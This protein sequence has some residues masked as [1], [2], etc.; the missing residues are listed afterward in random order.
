MTSAMVIGGVAV[1]ALVFMADGIFDVGQDPAIPDPMIQN[2]TA[3]MDQRLT[4]L[5]KSLHHEYVAPSA[6]P[7]EAAT[8]HDVQLLEKDVREA[9]EHTHNLQQQVETLSQKDRQDTG[10]SAIALGLTQLKMAYDNDLSLTPGIEALKKTVTNENLQKPL[11]E[12]SEITASGFPTKKAIYEELEQFRKAAQPA[13]LSPNATWQERA[14]NEF[15]KIVQIRP[16]NQVTQQSLITEIENALRTND[17]Q[18]ALTLVK[19]LPA[20]T[21]QSLLYKKIELRARAQM[22]LHDLITGATNAIG[23]GNQGKLY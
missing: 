6:L 19:Q 1:L 8:K 7:A 13:P 3:E 5:E 12:L 11:N 10:A 22:A 20:S 14:K 9:S 17:L 23:L 4:K 15:G 18:N 21:Q 2:Q 16:T